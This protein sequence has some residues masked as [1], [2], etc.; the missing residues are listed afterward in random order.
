MEGYR[1][2]LSS[3]TC[4]KLFSIS[5]LPNLKSLFLLFCKLEI[6]IAAL[7]ISYMPFMLDIFLDLL[8][9]IDENRNIIFRPILY[10]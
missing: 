7:Y 6:Q 10:F 1:F 4:V 5:T 3:E 9:S 2:T 8:I